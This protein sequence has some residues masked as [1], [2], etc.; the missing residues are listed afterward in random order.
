MTQILVLV[1]DPARRA[2]SPE[3]LAPVPAAGPAVWLSPGKA[4]EIPVGPELSHDRVR[5]FLGEDPVD[6]ALLPPEGRR[7]RLLLADMD[8]T[9]ITVE[10]LDELADFADVKPQVAAITERAMRGELDFKAAL[11]ERVAMLT[12]LEEA[13]LSRTYAERVTLTP[14]ARTLVMTMRRSGAYAAL[15]SGGFTYFTSRVREAAGFDVDLANRLVIDAGRLSGGVEEPIL[16]SAVKLSTLRR[17]AAE[18]GL[19][20]EDTLAVGDGANDLPMLQA[21]GLGVAFHAKPQV[22]AGARVR[23]E[24]G[25]LTTLLYFQGFRDAEFITD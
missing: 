5:E 18:R 11:R 12:G 22:A 19:A 25:D 15:V 24:H 17:L 14:G 21:A 7:K 16:D 9:I 23:V 10:C 20:E 8:S 6:F 13:A 3:D 2:L 4:V 1:A